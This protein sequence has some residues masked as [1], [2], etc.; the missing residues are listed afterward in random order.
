MAN[1]CGNKLL[2]LGGKKSVKEVEAFLRTAM[3]EREGACF[4]QKVLDLNKFI[5]IPSG[6]PEMNAALTHVQKR[7]LIAKFGHWNDYQWRKDQWG[8]VWDLIEVVQEEAPAKVTD[9]KA[10][11]GM[12]RLV[13]NG[14]PIVPIIEFLSG[15]FPLVGFVLVFDEGGNDLYGATAFFDKTQVDEIFF[16]ADELMLDVSEED[17]EWYEKREERALARLQ[18]IEAH[19]LDRLQVDT[20]LKFFSAKKLTSECD[21]Q[22]DYHVPLSANFEVM[23]E[24]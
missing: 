8:Q 2:Y 15:K 11:Q 7:E 5:P 22:G 9:S 17:P 13:T 18:E 1:L 3:S 12:F 16:S 21:E 4:L 19:L 10:Y 23:L 6:L 20:A 24:S 14:E